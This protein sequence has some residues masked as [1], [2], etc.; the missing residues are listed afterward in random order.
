V[1]VIWS[2]SGI[3][4][5][6]ALPAQVRY[7]TEFFCVSVLPDIEKNPCDGKRRKTFRGRYLH[8]NKVPAY[9]A[10]RSRQAIAP[11]KANGAAHLTYSPNGVARDFL[12][13]CHLKRE[14]AGFAASSAEGVLS[15]I[16]RIFER[17]PKD[18]LTGVYSK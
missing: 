12:L 11:T 15:E 14:M 13:F 3:H 10:M 17:I 9:N 18:I 6:V 8:L 7:N 2:K 1:S 5:L 4:S 16:R